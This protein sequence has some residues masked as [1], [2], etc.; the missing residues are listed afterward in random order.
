MRFDWAPGSG[1]DHRI[2]RDQDHAPGAHSIELNAAPFNIDHRGDRSGENSVER[3]LWP[4]DYPKIARLPE[5]SPQS[6]FPSGFPKK[7]I[8]WMNSSVIGFSCLCL[9]ALLP[10]NAFDMAHLLKRRPFLATDTVQSGG[11]HI[12]DLRGDSNGDGRPERLGDYVWTRGTVIA[13]PHTYETGG[14]LFWIRE[15][16]CGVLIY[17]EQED[18]SVGDSVSVSG[19][20]RITNGGYFFPETGMATLGDLA[21]E[22]AGVT[23]RG[24][25]ENVVPVVATVEQFVSRPETY[26][27]NLVTVTGLQILR[28]E[29]SPDGD[30]FI[31]M[32]SGGDS[33]L[34]CLDRDT[35]V[36]VG[37]QPGRCYAI[38]GIAVRMSAPS[39]LGPSPTWCIAPREQADVAASDCSAPLVPTTWGRTKTLVGD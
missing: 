22:N 35:G 27:G 23:R 3:P 18:L 10:L 14:W 31:R 17:G 25:S 6:T 16:A 30:R 19:I 8:S 5:V 15:G 24:R 29:Y 37:D 4:P 26:G 28:Q 7:L 11:D 33:I 34:I 13:E 32:A 39:C 20:L 12:C 9:L 21:V 36:S 2:D 38:T 1:R